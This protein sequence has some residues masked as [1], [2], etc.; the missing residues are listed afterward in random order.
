M[1]QLPEFEL[2][3]RAFWVRR[4]AT[5]RWLHFGLD[6]VTGVASSGPSIGSGNAE[7]VSGMKSENLVLTARAGRPKTTMRARVSF[8]RF[9][10]CGISEC[11]E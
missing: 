9:D 2:G 11:D 7:L 4:S 1:S 6:S 5:V 3:T 10:M 8:T